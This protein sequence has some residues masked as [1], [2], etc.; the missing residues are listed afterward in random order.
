MAIIQTLAV[1]LKANSG[2]FNKNM[3]A[4]GAKVGKLR[5]VLGGLGGVASLVGVGGFGAMIKGAIDAGDRVQKGTD[6]IRLNGFTPAREDL[7]CYVERGIG[8]S[9]DR[10]RCCAPRGLSSASAKAGSPAP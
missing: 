3:Q 5:S 9:R 6:Q 2:Q 1:N 7:P 4:A 8:V 10:G